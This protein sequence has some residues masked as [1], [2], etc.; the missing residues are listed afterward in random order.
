[1]KNILLKFCYAKPLFVTV[2][3]NR[4]SLDT[5]KVK[6]LFSNGFTGLHSPFL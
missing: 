6:L 2:S 3:N 4:Y 5:N 1:M